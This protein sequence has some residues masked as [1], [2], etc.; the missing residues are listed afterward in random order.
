MQRVLITGAGGFAAAHLARALQ[1]RGVDLRGYTL[2]TPAD[3]ALAAVTEL[4]DIADV[5]AL[6]IAIQRFEPDVIFHLAGVAATGNAWKQRRKVLE[7]NALGTVSCLEAMHA[8]GSR[9]RVVVMS[10]GL[11]YGRAGHDGA[12]IDEDTRPAP[13][14][15]YALSKAWAET[16]ALEMASSHTLD[17]VIARPFNFTGPGQGTG[18]V[19]S[20][21]ARQVAVAEQDPSATTIRVGNLEAE[22]DFADLRDVAAGLLAVAEHGATRRAYN[23]C[24]G[25]A[26]TVRSVLDML[27]DAASIELTVVQDP[28]LMRPVDVPRFV[29]SPARAAEELG[30]SAS[31]PF[32]ETLTDLLNWWR[33]ELS[34]DGEPRA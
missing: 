21:F 34:R 9:A 14:G 12:P 2:G 8:A 28:D 5:A 23:L 24:S 4:G 18:F 15:P 10:S 1:A 33:D 16:A 30:W 7:V 3:R 26:R 32:E 19:C 17:V 29:G 22:R 31:T 20:D 13:A 6:S 25:R 11:V 27:V